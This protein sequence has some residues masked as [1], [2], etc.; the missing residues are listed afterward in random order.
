MIKDFD[1]NVLPVALKTPTKHKV[2]E[3]KAIPGN[4]VMVP[5]E[6]DDIKD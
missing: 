3:E 4:A 2:E 6:V 5:P 1:D